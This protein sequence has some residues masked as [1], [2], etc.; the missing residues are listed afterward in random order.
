MISEPDINTCQ[1][2]YTCVIIRILECVFSHNWG[3]MVSPYGHIL[4]SSGAKKTAASLFVIPSSPYD[5]HSQCG[6]IGRYNQ[7]DAQAITSRMLGLLI[8]TYR[9]RFMWPPNRHFENRIIA[10]PGTV[11]NTLC[12][13]W[14]VTLALKYIICKCFPYFILSL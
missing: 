6:D 4:P 12:K 5:L 1:T 10:W 3:K 11:G 14:Y 8:L 2:T 9:D 7:L 13:E